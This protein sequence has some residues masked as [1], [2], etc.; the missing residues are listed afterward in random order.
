MLFQSKQKL[1]VQARMNCG[2]IMHTFY[3]LCFFRSSDAD[4]EFD[5]IIGNIEDIIMGIH[6]S[7]HKVDFMNITC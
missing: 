1:F 3:I 5:M 4:A 7:F 2:N 6:L